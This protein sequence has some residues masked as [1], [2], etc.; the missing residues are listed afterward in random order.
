MFQ[1]RRRDSIT[2][3]CDS[4]ALVR[5]KSQ[6][7]LTARKRSCVMQEASKTRK[8]LVSTDTPFVLSKRL[9]LDGEVASRSVM[10]RTTRGIH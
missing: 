8:R 7:S 2:P 10:M 1:F 4:S 6:K 5:R 3:Y 9:R